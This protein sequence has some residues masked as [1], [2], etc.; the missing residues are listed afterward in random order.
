M[1][2][3]TTRGDEDEGHALSR[4]ARQHIAARSNNTEDFTRLGLMLGLLIPGENPDS[5]VV[6]ASPFDAD[7]SD[8]VPL[9]SEMP[10]RSA[11][12]RRAA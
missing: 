8:V 2:A 11:R 3:I 7:V 10:S 12:L 9:D 5:A 6:P 4:M 1:T